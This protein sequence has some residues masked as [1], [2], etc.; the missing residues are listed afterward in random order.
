MVETENLTSVS[1][2]GVLFNKHLEP[3][4]KI[5]SFKSSDLD[6]KIFAQYFPN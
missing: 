6:E 3:N 2:I 1:T 4:V 5:F